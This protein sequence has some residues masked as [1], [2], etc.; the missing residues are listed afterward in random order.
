MSLLDLWLFK[1][2]GSEHYGL[3]NFL[4][5]WKA[6]SPHL[7]H[8][9]RWWWPVGRKW[10]V[11]CYCSFL[12]MHIVKGFSDD[13]E[14]HQSPEFHSMPWHRWHITETAGHRMELQ[15][16]VT[17]AT[18]FLQDSLQTCTK[19]K[20]HRILRPLMQKKSCCRWIYMQGVVIDVSKQQKLTE[21][22]MRNSAVVPKPYIPN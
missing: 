14:R 17:V 19:E 6:N 10:L 12:I 4:N 15:I 22:T 2:R 18:E 7:L 8:G 9:L 1:V 3:P 21:K 5:E 11:D 13:A 16:I 20:C